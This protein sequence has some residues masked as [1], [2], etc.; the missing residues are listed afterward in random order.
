V[1][2][3]SRFIDLH[4]SIRRGDLSDP[5]TIIREALECE[6]QLEKWE[7]E[8]P[9]IWKFMIVTGT[10]A[11]EN[12]YREQYQVYRDLWSCRI[13][14]HYRWTRILANELILTHLVKLSPFPPEYVGRHDIATRITKK[15][16]TDIC[17]SV[18]A[19]FFRHHMPEAAQ[20]FVPYMSGVFLL[21]FP[22]AVA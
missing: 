11:E 8:V 14:N 5:E 9:L 10:G 17:D 4:A 2:I 18:A 20:L 19:Q 1:G 6:A 16:A 7:T 15:M 21:L 12:L 13:W 22:L 3:V